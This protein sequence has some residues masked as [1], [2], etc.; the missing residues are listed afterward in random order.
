MAARSFLMVRRAS[1]AVHGR[2]AARA[3]RSPGPGTSDVRLV[4]ALGGPGTML[5]RK[6][7]MLRMEGRPA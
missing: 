3:A 1:G 4:L 6:M 2:D 5:R 7:T